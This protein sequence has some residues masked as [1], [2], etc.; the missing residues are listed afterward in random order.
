MDVVE[1]NAAL[2]KGGTRACAKQLM[3]MIEDVS[4]MLA[5]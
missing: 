3:Q 1:T 5:F 2:F 4:I